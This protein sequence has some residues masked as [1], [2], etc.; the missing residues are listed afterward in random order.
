MHSGVANAVQFCS[1]SNLLFAYEESIWLRTSSEVQP[2]TVAREVH[3]LRLSVFYCS[4]FES[5][6]NG[7][8]I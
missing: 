1:K 6:Q 7:N 3:V 4:W 2:L 5:V 8:T